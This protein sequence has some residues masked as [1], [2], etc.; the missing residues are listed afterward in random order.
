MKRF[1]VDWPKTRLMSIESYAVVLVSNPVLMRPSTGSSGPACLTLCRPVIMDEI[2]TLMQQAASL[3]S[4]GALARKG[5][6][7]AAAEGC[8]RDAL[9]LAV[10]AANR[11]IDA[12][13]Q[14]GRLDAL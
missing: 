14:P 12:R 11:A 13:L 3:G 5:G 2:E 9:S 1:T 8:F 7:E 4:S 6:D 10:E